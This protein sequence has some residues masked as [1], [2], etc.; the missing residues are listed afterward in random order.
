MSS[1]L[2]HSYPLRRVLD[3]GV[4]RARDCP[5]SVRCYT[6]E[7]DD[8]ASR[9]ERCSVILGIPASAI[10]LPAPSEPLA[11]TENGAA[12]G[13]QVA[14]LSTSAVPISP[15]VVK[16]V[17]A[18]TTLLDLAITVLHSVRDSVDTQYQ[19]AAAQLEN[20]APELAPSATAAYRRMAR[21]PLPHYTIELSTGVVNAEGRAALLPLGTVE[22]RQVV[23]E[24]PALLFPVAHRDRTDYNASLL[25][26]CYSAGDPVLFRCNRTQ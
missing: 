24:H 22:L 18:D 2:Q 1:V 4:K 26:Q 25:A 8:I 23:Q 15:A 7:H 10:P 12:Q 17:W 6:L 19:N 20:N 13:Q 16:Y 11:S 9:V 3:H 5:I 14:P 21:D